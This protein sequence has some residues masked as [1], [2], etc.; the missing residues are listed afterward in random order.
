MWVIDLLG[1]AAVAGGE[2]L[3]LALGGVEGLGQGDALRPRSSRGRRRGGRRSC[4]R[5]GPR[6]G[7]PRPASRSGRGPAGRSSSTT[8][9]RRAVALAFAIRTA[10]AATR[11]ASAVVRWWLAAKPQAPSTSDADAEPLA[12]ARLDALDAG[13]LDVDRFLEPPD[14]AHVRVAG[15]Q[16]GGR[17]EGTVRQI[18]HWPRVAT[19]VRTRRRAKAVMPASADAG[20]CRAPD[21][22]PGGATRY[23]DPVARRHAH[24]A[25][26]RWL[27][28]LHVAIQSRPIRPPRR[29]GDTC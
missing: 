6:T 11:S 27:E 24:T 15:A 7:P 20:S 13:G 3:P 21:H 29:G 10:S 22:A 19:S 4:A 18:A 23:R 2:R 1:E 16:G 14:H 25:R 8:G 17:V 28:C 12:L 26:W 9:L 5:A